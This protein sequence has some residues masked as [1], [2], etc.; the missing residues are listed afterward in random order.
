MNKRYPL[1]NIEE[2]ISETEELIEVEDSIVS[3]D[4]DSQII[5]SSWSVYIE[6]LNLTFRQGIVCVWDENKNMFMPDLD[7]TIVYEKN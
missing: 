7:P 1:D 4:S 2:V 6:S 5:V 3:I